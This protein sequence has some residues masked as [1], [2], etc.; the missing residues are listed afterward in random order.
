MINFAARL[1]MWRKRLVLLRSILTCTGPRRIA[2]AL[3]AFCAM[4][5]M[6]A[7]IGRWTVNFGGQHSQFY[8]DVYDRESCVESANGYLVVAVRRSFCLDGPP[9][10]A[11]LQ[12]S[13]KQ[14]RT[15]VP[16]HVSASMNFGPRPRLGWVAEG[17]SVN[18]F[19][20]EEPPRPLPGIKLIWEPTTTTEWYQRVIEVHWSLL[21]AATALLLG[22][23]LVCGLRWPRIG[24]CRTCGY[25]LRATPDR[26]PE[27]GSITPVSRESGCA[28]SKPIGAVDEATNP[29]IR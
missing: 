10:P 18:Q 6:W 20:D 3:F 9:V 29:A 21:T 15:A 5:L 1:S 11:N 24:H 12:G 14:I 28:N 23:V 7:A 13:I 16:W 27:C 4:N 26:C 25:D 19:G 2:L 22:V 17:S 8:E